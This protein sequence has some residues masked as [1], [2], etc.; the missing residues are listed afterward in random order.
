M[1]KKLILLC[2]FM[3]LFTTVKAEDVLQVTPFSTHA[4]VVEDDWETF[5]VEMVNTA[6]YTALQ[7]DLYLP[8]GL[9]LIS[10]GPMELSPDRFPGYTRKGV[11]YPDHNYEC[12]LMNDGHYLIT[13]YS[14]DL[15]VIDGNEGE[16]LI[17]YYETDANMTAGY[18]PIKVANTVLT[19]DSHT[20]FKP[21]TSTSFVQIGEPETFDSEILSGNVPSFVVDEIP[22]D[23]TSY[24]FT[25]VDNMDAAF[26]P[27]N[28]NCIQYVKHGSSYAESAIGNV[29]DN[30]VC[31]NLTINDG[32]DF[33]VPTTFTAN[34]VN[35]QRNVTADWG[36]ICLP[37]PVESNE[38]VQYY[39]YQEI[40]GSTITFVKVDGLQA[41]EPG[42]F[43]NIADA[44]TMQFSS[45][46]VNI[47]SDITDTDVIEGLK[48][49]G[50]YTRQRIDVDENAPSYY[51][52]DNAFRRGV[53]YFIIPAFRAYFASEVAN[54]AKQFNIAIMDEVTGLKTVIGNLD[55]KTGDIYTINGIK[56]NT[57]P[58]K[59]LF[60]S[61]G[62]KHL[63]K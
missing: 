44:N 49:V 20:D 9:T 32:Y 30:G 61:D 11:F 17:F 13:I 60:I 53:D 10:D 35:Y 27:E 2:G 33:S 34:T 37:Y 63:G 36:T 15:E 5:S 22:T 40:N 47:A 16:I 39:Q 23:Q 62:K 8:D 29:V 26:I 4:G 1:N 14:S 41:G 51:I 57:P 54:N 59:G 58:A 21:A 7:F 18:Y 55:S 28:P 46:S 43:C 19:V 38:N 3:L 48:L 45:E 25:N 50:T 24:D 31:E 56:V 6:A 12:T 42:V 52:K